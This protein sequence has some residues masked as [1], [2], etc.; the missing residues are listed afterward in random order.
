MGLHPDFLRLPVAHRGLHGPGVPENSMAAFRAAIAAGYGIECDIQRA[1]DG[2]ALVFHDDDLPR[3]TGAEGLVSALGIDALSM[4]RIMGTEEHIPTLA[5][6]LDEVAGRVPLLIEI[7]DQSMRSSAE[8]G[9]LQ[10][11]V[12]RLLSGYD[13]PVAVM[14]FNPHAVAAFH[15]AAPGVTVGLTTCGYEA[16]DWPMLDDATRAHLAAIGD[17]DRVGASFISHDRRDLG[18]PAVAALKARGVPVLCW[19]VRSTAAEAEAR[20]VADNITFEHY[21]PAKP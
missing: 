2:T 12:A 20:R 18:N 1:S 15:A 17:F 19:T 14:S 9:D 21:L 11:E 3:L 16:G 10:A 5:E 6:L 7:K 13:G 8:V 4:L